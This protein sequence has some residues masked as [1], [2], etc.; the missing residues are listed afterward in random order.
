MVREEKKKINFP[1][2]VF[3]IYFFKASGWQ[4]AK[5]FTLI[6]EWRGEFDICPDDE[7]HF[8]FD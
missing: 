7:N 2:E 4:T 6:Y 5:N 1:E 8:K 3:D